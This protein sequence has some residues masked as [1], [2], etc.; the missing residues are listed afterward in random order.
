MKRPQKL[1]N[2]ENED[3]YE[4]R[5][6]DEDKFSFDVDSRRLTG[7]NSSV[8][9]V[10]RNRYCNCGKIRTLCRNRLNSGSFDI[11]KFDKGES[12][13]V[14][15]KSLMLNQFLEYSSDSNETMKTKN[16]SNWFNANIVRNNCQHES[17]TN[18]FSETSSRSEC[19]KNVSVVYLPFS[20]QLLDKS[21]F[22]IFKSVALYWFFCVNTM[23]IKG[24]VIKR[25]NVITTGNDDNNSSN[26]MNYNEKWSFNSY[27]SNEKTS[28]IVHKNFIDNLTYFSS[29]NLLDSSKENR[30]KKHSRMKFGEKVWPNVVRKFIKSSHISVQKLV[31]T[32]ISNLIDVKMLLVDSVGSLENNKCATFQ[33]DIITDFD[34]RTLHE[35]YRRC[36]RQLY[37]YD[38]NE[39]NLIIIKREVYD[40]EIDF[41]KIEISNCN[42][43]TLPEIIEN[44]IS[45]VLKNDFTNKS[46]KRDS[47]FNTKISFDMNLSKN[48]KNDKKRNGNENENEKE[49]EIEMDLDWINSKK[50]DHNTNESS[51]S[52]FL[53][54]DWYFLPEGMFAFDDNE[55]PQYNLWCSPLIIDQ[56]LSQN[57]S[58]SLRSESMLN[59]KSEVENSG[60]NFKPYRLWE[61]SFMFEEDRFPNTYSREEEKFSI[62]SMPYA[63]STFKSQTNENSSDYSL[64]A[65]PNIIE[66][67][68]GIGCLQYTNDDCCLTD[69]S[70]PSSSD[71]FNS[72]C[73]EEFLDILRTHH[74]HENKHLGCEQFSNFKPVAGGLVSFTDQGAF[75]YYKKSVINDSLETKIKDN[76]TLSYDEHVPL[77]F[78]A[79]AQSV[80]LDEADVEVNGINQ[81]SDKS[82]KNDQMNANVVHI[83]K[84][85]QPAFKVETDAPPLLERSLSGTYYNQ[86][87]KLYTFKHEL[88][89]N[90]T[91]N[92]HIFQPKFVVSKNDKACQTDIVFNCKPL[93]IRK[94]EISFYYKSYDEKSLPL[95]FSN[96]SPNDEF[97]YSL[98]DVFS[99][100]GRPGL[101]NIGKKIILHFIIAVI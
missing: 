94:N 64:W 72:K 81:T 2:D 76:F 75:K 31:Q 3:A 55:Y 100:L 70:I 95:Q 74:H 4:R 8:W 84:P 15:K 78:Y 34:K 87:Q 93:M 53:H 42:N 91:S 38:D 80:M 86:D 82:Y 40:E 14:T 61:S 96:Q 62:F 77:S 27:S 5:Y 99:F 41:M 17:R 13:Y 47:Y 21:I 6:K 92:H 98:R 18:N 63:S 35:I 39:Y 71:S 85:I 12:I 60:T 22:S 54:E 50:N 101:A 16:N 28:F 24:E 88:D 26:C 67:L 45:T 29:Q 66:F 46:I 30:Y 10:I 65:S 11:F 37:E 20:A 69:V 58:S 79:S 23:C 57:L 97:L 33:F 59:I 73:D 44:G 89:V 56:V 36:D 49:N 7:S 9:F 25:K 19:K 90:L 83:F 32:V 1:A 52:V 43:F 68:P 51:N 48:G